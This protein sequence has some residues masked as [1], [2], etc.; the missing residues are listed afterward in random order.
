MGFKES[1]VGGDKAGKG[2]SRMLRTSEFVHNCKQT[3]T[4]GYLVGW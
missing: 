2:M 3:V 1:K 4:G